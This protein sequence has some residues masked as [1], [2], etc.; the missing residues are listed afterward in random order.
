MSEGLLDDCWCAEKSNSLRCKKI[1]HLSS[2]IWKWAGE[3]RSVLHK[4]LMAAGKLIFSVLLNFQM[5][6]FYSMIYT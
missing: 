6:H 1:C 3:T 2:I 5:T 4:G